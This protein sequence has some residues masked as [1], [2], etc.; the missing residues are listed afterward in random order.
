MT[1]IIREYENNGNLVYVKDSGGYESWHE[2]DANGNFIYNKFCHLG[3]VIH[4]E[5]WKYDGQSRCVHYK[6]SKGNE[7]WWEYDVSGKLVYYKKEMR[8]A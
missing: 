1:D 4:E 8:Y 3:S 6:N 5:W 2:R 7:E